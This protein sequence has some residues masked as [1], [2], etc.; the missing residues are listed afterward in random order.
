MTTRRRCVPAALVLPALC[1]ITL[2]GCAGGR[3]VADH[4]APAYTP[5]EVAYAASDRDLA[6]VLHGA[7]PG[8]DPATLGPAVTAAM[9]GRIMGVRTNFTTTPGESARPDYRVVMAFNPVEPLLSSALCASGPV[10][11]RAPAAAGGGLV[12]EAAFCRGGGALTAARGT[13]ESSAGPDD[14]EF[15]GLIGDIT[16]ALF[17]AYRDSDTNICVGANC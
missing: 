13:L 4:P 7:P 6:V 14:P 1:A 3:V 10:P 12:V 5:G 2:W 11:T 15:R 9:Q 16:F 8:T 17:P